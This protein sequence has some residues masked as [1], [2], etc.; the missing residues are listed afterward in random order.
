MPLAERGAGR[1]VLL[2]RQQSKLDAAAAAIRSQHG[3]DVSVFR[4]DLGSATAVQEVAAQITNRHRPAR[5][6]SS[7]APVPDCCW[8]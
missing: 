6:P 7:T 5:H 1:I 2:A 3:T 8:A 4:A